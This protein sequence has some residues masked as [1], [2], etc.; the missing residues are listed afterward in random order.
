VAYKRRIIGLMSIDP[1]WI[2]LSLIPGGIGMVLFVYGKKQGR[3][4]MVVA[5]LVFM[6]YPYFTETITSLLVVGVVLG[7]VTWVGIRDSGW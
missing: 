5:G 6:V 4:G 2:F 3:W 7:A 1:L